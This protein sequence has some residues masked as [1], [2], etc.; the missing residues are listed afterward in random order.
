MPKN[1]SYTDDEDQTGSNSWSFTISIL[2]GLLILIT[3]VALT[4]YLGGVY[5]I[6]FGVPLVIIGLLIPIISQ[7]ALAGK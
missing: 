1:T 3:G 2:I 4:A 7:F 6:I 5:S